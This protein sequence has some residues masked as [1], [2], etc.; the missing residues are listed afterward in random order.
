MAPEIVAD[1]LTEEEAKN[2]ERVLIKELDTMNPE[3]GY[4]L[5][6]G[7]EMVPGY[8]YS[9]MA[10]KKMSEKKQGVFDG[11]K[12]PM[13]GKHQSEETRRKISEKAKGRPSK[14]KGKHLNL[15]PEQKKHASEI[16]KGKGHPMPESAKK[17]LSEQRKGVP[18]SEESKKKLS[19]TKRNQAKEIYCVELDRV[20]RS[21][22]DAQDELNISLCT[23]SKCCTKHNNTAGGYHWKFYEEHL[24]EIKENDSASDCRTCTNE[25]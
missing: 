1:G 12:N 22:A 20:F 9:E 15:S 10:R 17:K 16:R 19:E 11:E 3:H 18:K 2:F 8:R 5:T 24:K 6:S 7:G 21:M 25:N 13:Y 14:M 4:N 23:L